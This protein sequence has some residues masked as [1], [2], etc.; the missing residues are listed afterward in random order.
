MSDTIRPD[1][2]GVIAD[3][4]PGPHRTDTDEILTGTERV[5]ATYESCVRGRS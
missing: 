5:F 1:R 3:P 2:I 4:T